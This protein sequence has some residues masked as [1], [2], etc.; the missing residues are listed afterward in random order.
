VFDL[1]KNS[2]LVS[3]KI[4]SNSKCHWD[5]RIL[6]IFEDMNEAEQRLSDEAH[7]WVK[8][9][10]LVLIEKFAPLSEHE[11]GVPAISLFMAG[12]P[13]AGKTEVSKRLIQ[14]FVQKPVRIDADEIRAECQGYTGGNAHVFQKAANKGV[15]IL[16]DHALGEG[17]NLILDATFAHAEVQQNIQ[18]SLDKQ[19]RVEIFFIYQDPIVAWDFTKKREVL[20]GRRVTKD[21]FID[22]FVKSRENVNAMKREFG[23]RVE[24]NL[25]EKNIQ[26]ESERLQ[27]DIAGVD[28]Y[29]K[30]IY[31][32][33]ELESLLW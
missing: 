22:A 31:T 1:W 3:Y 25:I 15:N 32:R 2:A 13:G 19:R 30:K 7:R 11:K 23:D 26:E 5:Y 29:L 10:E 6:G 16:Y 17:L 21:K 24:L 8:E 33:N 9:N 28:S 12:S 14:R 27:L 4:V 18:R 20:E